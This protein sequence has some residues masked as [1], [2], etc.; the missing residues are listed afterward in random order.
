[1]KLYSEK[2]FFKKK[3]ILYFILA[4]NVVSAHSTG[5]TH[6]ELAGEKLGSITM[7]VVD[8]FKHGLA[9]TTGVHFFFLFAGILFFRRPDSSKALTNAD[10]CKKTARRLRNLFRVYLIWNALSVL[11]NILLQSIPGISSSITARAMYDWSL[12]ALLEGI[13]FYKYNGPFYY[14]LWLMIDIAIAPIIFKLLKNKK[15]SIFLCA[16]SLVIYAYIYDYIYGQIQI[17]PDA[18]IF[19][20]IGGFIGYYYYESLHIVA[21]KKKSILCLTLTAVILLVFNV[22]LD[23]CNG[24][25]INA[26]R[27]ISELI[28]F[29]TIWYTIDLLARAKDSDI[30]IDTFWVYCAHDFI[31]PCVNK[32]IFILMPHND[33]FILINMFGGVL[34]TYIIL[35][36]LYWILSYDF[37]RKI[38]M[39]VLLQG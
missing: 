36:I 30:W 37:F 18:I 35:Y 13:F 32:L 7:M 25:G 14:I 3:N 33:L 34:I 38:K 16:F 17:R 6:Y 2:E 22:F 31:E 28:L 27:V 23:E 20:F 24:L 4:L 8:Y 12:G 5:Y 11:Y 26:L 21:S 15:I 19:F 10:V 1:M 9:I 29:Y 39:L